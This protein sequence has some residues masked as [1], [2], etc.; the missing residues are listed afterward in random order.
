MKITA[1]LLTACFSLL[2]S[3][4]ANAFGQDDKWTSG[5]G[6]GVSEAIV[7]HGPGNQIYVTCDKGAGRSD[8]TAIS[9]MLAGKS[10]KGDHIVA[11]FDNEEP[12]QVWIKDG[13]ITTE[14]HAC[15]D[16]YVYLIDKFKTHKWVHILF[17]NGNGAKFTLKGAKEAISE[18]TPEFY[19]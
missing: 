5:F 11:T 6:Q 4:N 18:C 12:F 13:Q 8:V 14:C 7:T 19:K 1:L 9:F 3:I 17:E 2:F 15:A 10:P 16:N